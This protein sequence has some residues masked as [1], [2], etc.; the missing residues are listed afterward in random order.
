MKISFQGEIKMTEKHKY[1]ALTFD[2]GPNTVTTPQ[3]L[4]VL[5]KHGIKA[6]FFVV[7]NNINESSA[8]VMKQAHDMGCDIENHSRTHSAMSEMPADEVLAEIKYTSD[9]VEEITGRRPRF[10]RP[11]YIALSDQLF[12]TVDM[13][14]ICGKGCEDWLDE[15]SPDER[16]KRII[17]QLR[18]GLI[19]LMHDM[20]GNFRTVEAI[21]K[22]IPQ[23]KAMGYEFVTISELFEKTGVT[24]LT[25]KDII[26][27]YAEQT[28]PFA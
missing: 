7:G 24:P 19:I 15:I 4:E 26:Y 8:K 27:S 9:K 3:V 14:F 1:L 6:S 16:V 28:E 12:K 2:D 5:K 13:P 22:I 21:D 17:E 23:A 18:D 11:P 20:E 25:D 10:F